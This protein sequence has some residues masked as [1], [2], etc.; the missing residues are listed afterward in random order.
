M[1]DY[2]VTYE[3]RHKGEPWNQ[4]WFRGRLAPKVPTA[5]EA[6]WMVKKLAEEDGLSMHDV[7]VRNTK[8]VVESA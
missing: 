2:L 1:A 4:G 5:R 7:E 8:V 3:A 6:A